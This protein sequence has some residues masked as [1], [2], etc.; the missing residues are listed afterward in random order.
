[1]R[2]SSKQRRKAASA[3]FSRFQSVRGQI[4]TII[5]IADEGDII[6]PVQ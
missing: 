4:S 1:M 2:M 3:K 6:E 5:R